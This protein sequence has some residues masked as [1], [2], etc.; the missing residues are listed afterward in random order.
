[1]AVNSTQNSDPQQHFLEP[2]A[3]A[4]APLSTNIIDFPNGQEY[5]DLAGVGANVPPT[6]AGTRSDGTPNNTAVP[7][8]TFQP[9][10]SGNFFKLANPA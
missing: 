9:R 6:G 4:L 5:N 1:M 10:A 7:A 2:P 3:S 8:T